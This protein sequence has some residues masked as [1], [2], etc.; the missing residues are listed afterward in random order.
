VEEEWQ[1]ELVAV[2]LIINNEAPVTQFPVVI[3]F[4]P[5]DKLLIYLKA[6]VLN[7]PH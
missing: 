2:T 7:V 5:R 1:L 3:F 6:I 4:N